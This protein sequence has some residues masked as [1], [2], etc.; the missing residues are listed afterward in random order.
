MEGAVLGRPLP[1]TLA[2][3]LDIVADA[4]IT[5]DGS[6]SIIYYNHGAEEI[7]G[8]AAADVLGQSLHVLL[9]PRF[10]AAH[11]RHLNGF[12]AGSANARLMGQRQEVF[13]RRAD[14]NEFPAEVS[15]SKLTEGGEVYL[16]AIV[17]D[18]TER[19]KQEQA[20][21]QAMAALTDREAALS[22]TA[23]RLRTSREE[24][25][26]LSRRLVESLEDERR[27]IARELHDE[28]GQ[29]LTVLALGVGSL[30]KEFQFSPG[31]HN[32]ISELKRQI[33]DVQE[34]L[35]RLAANLRP[36]SL[37]RLGLVPALQQYV[38]DF[39]RQSGLPIQFVSAG[40]EPQHLP[41]DA[42]TALYRIAQ[43]ALTNVVRH[44][45]ANRAGVILELRDESVLLIIEDDGVGFDVGEAVQRRRLGLTG[46]RE[47]AETMRGQVSVESAPGAGTT[48]FVRVPLSDER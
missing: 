35:H 16:T 48:L 30:E 19:K 38:E 43:E 7:F 5:V 29:A 10:A 42:K 41:G 6:Q 1:A 18:V 14:G 32:R 37:D 40:G 8:Y 21:R 33:S 9:P 17:R 2:G 47:R 26:G 27:S 36:V 25:Q 22:D 11:D 34:G 20:L 24:L 15:I 28:A 3:I 23:A 44:A 45:K 12:R 39:G 4:V 46:I 13:G 31:V